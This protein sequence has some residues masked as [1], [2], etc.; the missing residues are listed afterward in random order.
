MYAPTYYPGVGSVA[1]ARAVTVG[2]S[3]EVVDIDFG[4]QLVPN[5][6]RQRPRRESRWILDSQ[7]QRQL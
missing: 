4:L 7:G 3:Q 5:G 1:D 6:A 2:V